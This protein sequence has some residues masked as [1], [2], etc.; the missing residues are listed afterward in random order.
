M[1]HSNSL[2]EIIKEIIVEF[3]ISYKFMDKI[4]KTKESNYSSMKYI[5]L[6]QF[7]KALY[8]E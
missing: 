5:Q 2:N 3:K 8:K 1:S 4:I 6:R 7:L